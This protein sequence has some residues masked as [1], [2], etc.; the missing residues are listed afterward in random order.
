MKRISPRRV[1]TW[2]GGAGA[3]ALAAIAAAALVATGHHARDLKLKR[4]LDLVPGVL[5]HAR[6]F[7]WTQMKANRKQWELWAREASYSDD[8]TSLRLS[9]PELSMVLDDGKTLLL[10]AGRAKLKLNGNEV[11][12]A[13]LNGGV[14]LDYGDIR[15]S[16]DQATF[17]PSRDDLEASGEVQVRG[18]DFKLNGLGLT[19]HPQA[20]LFALQHRVR[21]EFRAGRRSARPK[22]S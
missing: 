18:A 22:K 14:E 1:A 5:L 2:L 13:E 11:R 12:V 9:A 20:R 15:L 3:L 17:V 10:R 7:H 19:A 8:K 16:T 4:G 6:N 21:T